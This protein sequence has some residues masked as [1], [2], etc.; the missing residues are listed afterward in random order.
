[1]SFDVGAM[2]EQM[3]I[4]LPNDEIKKRLTGVGLG[5]NEVEK[6][7]GYINNSRLKYSSEKSEDKK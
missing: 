5:D 4:K 1:M 2:M 3:L 6:I 7:L